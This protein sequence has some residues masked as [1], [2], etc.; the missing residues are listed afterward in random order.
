M[1]DEEP[2]GKLEEWATPT[3]ISVLSIPGRK[4]NLRTSI[5]CYRFRDCV[6]IAS[7]TNA[8]LKS[9]S[10][11]GFVPRV[12]Q[13]VSIVNCPSHLPE[14]FDTL[15]LRTRRGGG[16][17]TERCEEA[18]STRDRALKNQSH[19]FQTVEPLYLTQDED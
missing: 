11:G 8:R 4:T 16:L 12:E 13:D 14:E 5:M 9:V 2:K 17:C 7:V 1:H 3:I 18:I 6:L 15:E 19:S 10:L